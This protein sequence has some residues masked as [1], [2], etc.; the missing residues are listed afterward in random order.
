MAYLERSLPRRSDLGQVLPAVR[1]V[2]CLAMNYGTVGPR[3]YPAHRPAVALY[4]H[5]RDYHAVLG[6]R[7]QALCDWISEIGGEGTESLWYVDTGPILERDLAQ[8]A[9]LGFIGK[10]TNLI[11]RRFGNWCFLAEILTTLEL[12]PDDS[13]TNH[14]GRCT[15]C[16]QACPTR[17]IVAPFQLDARRCLSYLTIEN[18]GSIP[19]EFRVPIGDRLFGCDDCLAVC[20][21]NRFATEARALKEERLAGVADLD[22]ASVFELTEE[23]FRQQFSGTALLRTK[24][25]GLVRNACVVVGNTR[26]VEVLPQLGRLS[27]DPDSMIAEHAA[28]AADRIRSRV[29]EV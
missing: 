18:R 14:C 5:Y 7:L 22:P 3:G 12:E 8:R 17:A 21:W 16:I 11:H 26:G 10:H 13:E 27:S 25:R 6:R 1:S 15:L 9:G 24:R 20:P 28:W 29:G 19:V 23:Q 2:L 4:A